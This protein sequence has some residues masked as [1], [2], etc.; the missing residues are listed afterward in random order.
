MQYNLESN[1]WG[2]GSS[3]RVEFI[4]PYIASVTNPALVKMMQERASNPGVWNHAKTVHEKGSV[5]TIVASAACMGS[6]ENNWVCDMEKD[7][8]HV[9]GYNGTAW[10]STAFPLGTCVQFEPIGASEHLNYSIV[11]CVR[12]NSVAT[13]ALA[14]WHIGYTS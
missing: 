4:K 13:A 2:A 11:T 8:G 10:V 3:N 12:G 1:F 7:L 6:G 14:L 9:G 5:G